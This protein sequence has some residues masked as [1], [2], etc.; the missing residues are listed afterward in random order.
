MAFAKKAS[1]GLILGGVWGYGKGV[2]ETRNGMVTVVAAVVGGC[3][4]YG[5]GLV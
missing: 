4:V 5:E 2:L 1:V 3:Y